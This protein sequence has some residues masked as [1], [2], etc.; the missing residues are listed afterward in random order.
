MFQFRMEESRECASW[1]V[2]GDVAPDG[3]AAIGLFCKW[4]ERIASLEREILLNGVDGSKVI[5]FCLTQFEETKIDVRTQITS[6][7][8][9]M[10]TFHKALV[11]GRP[12][13]RWQCRPR[14]FPAIQ[15]FCCLWRACLCQEFEIDRT[16][17]LSKPIS[18]QSNRW[19]WARAIEETEAMGAWR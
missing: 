4:S 16:F 14:L 3:S 9:A 17:N 1:S 10:P 19:S 6:M 7:S 15:T 12:R 18:S 11:H 13:G 2:A 5:V 8:T